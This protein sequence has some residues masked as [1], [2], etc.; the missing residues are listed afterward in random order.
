VTGNGRNK[1]MAEPRIILCLNSGSSSL[2]FTLFCMDEGVETRLAE[3]SARHIGTSQGQLLINDGA[4]NPLLQQRREFS[5]HKE[6]V[7][8]LLSAPELRNLP[9]PVALGHRVVHGGPQHAA[10]VRVT[11][12]LLEQLRAYV[13]LARQHLPAQLEVM[14]FTTAAL[15]SLPQV[16]CF[17]TA[18]HHSLP[19]L[20]QRL[21]LPRKLWDDGLRRYGFHG[22]SFEYIV[23]ALGESVKGA[24]VI[25]HLGN[26]ASLAALRDGQPI[27]TT[28]GLTPTGGLMMGTRSGD[29][30]PGVLLYLLD[31]HELNSAELARLVEEE[32]GLKGVSGISSDMREL[33]EA[34]YSQPYAAQ[35]IDMFCYTAG[36]HI[37][38]MAAALGGLD[39]LVFTGGIGER[40]ASVREAI[41]RNLAF[42]GVSLD[43]QRNGRSADIISSSDN[44]CS[45]RVIPT[46][47]DL[48]VARH[49]RDLI[50]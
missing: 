40:A 19:E 50:F 23:Q 37:G 31:E 21:P 39:T 29:L 17:D 8:S 5:S 30:D 1:V 48:M 4:G 6:I 49:T 12:Q 15:P 20:A 13:P 11:V 2:K 18:F 27:D 38:A 28:M 47:E 33:L 42:M 16:A 46:D 14:Q 9:A 3:G 10:P 44:R 35:A 34:S 22:L 43:H 24:T 7:E 45:V 26:G 36:K 32:A 41:C 25:A